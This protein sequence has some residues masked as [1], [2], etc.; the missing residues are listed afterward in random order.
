MSDDEDTGDRMDIDVQFGS[1]A[2]VK[3]KRIVRDLPV[4]A[5]DSLPWVE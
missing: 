4:E 2:N 3:G 1:D 5:E